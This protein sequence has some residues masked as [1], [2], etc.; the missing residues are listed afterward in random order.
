MGN[1]M[2]EYGLLELIKLI[3]PGTTT[4]D[5]ILNGECFDKAIGAHLLIDAA[6]YQNVMMNKFTEEELG[7]MKTFMEKLVDGKMGAK[8]TAL[9]VEFV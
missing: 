4:A 9:R 3:N 5:H 7:G 6:M 1:F 2:A 8:H